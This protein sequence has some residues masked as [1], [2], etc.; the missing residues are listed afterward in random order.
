MSIKYV[1]GNI[2]TLAK[3]GEFDVIAHGCNCFCN[4]G[5]GLARDIKREFPGGISSRSKN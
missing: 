3:E 5:A 4:F 1:K 2:I